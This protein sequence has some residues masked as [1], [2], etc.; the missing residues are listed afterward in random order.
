MSSAISHQDLSALIGRTY[1]CALDPSR[2]EATLDAIRAFL[3]CLTVQ[4]ALMDLRQQRILLSKD[5]GMDAQLHE[6]TS[7]HLPEFQ[8]YVERSLDNGRSMEEL[9]VVSRMD[10]P[11]M[12]AG[13]FYREF[14]SLGFIDLVQ[15]HLL[16]SPTRLS[17][18]G[19]CRQDSAGV[20]DDREIEILRLLI[21][22]VRRAVT[23]SNVLDVQA[24]EKARMAETLDALKLGVVLTN[25][26]SRILHANRAAEEMMRNG[27]TIR[28][29][30]GVL[31]AEGGAASVEIR[32]AIRQAARDESGIGKTGPAVRLPEEDEPPVVAPRS[33]LIAG[34]LQEP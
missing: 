33:Q 17:A 8:H 2:W 6:R 23:I 26:D 30:G 16:R 10:S 11:E 15:M 3:R 25:E 21:P 9:I 18:L 28:E 27:G 20:F 13:P 19:F 1:D 5:L 12:F 31:R 34:G 22:H 29:R 4:L 32:S 14:L 24:I 7:R